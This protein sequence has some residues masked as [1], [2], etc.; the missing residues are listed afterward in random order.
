[1]SFGLVL[2]LVNGFPASAATLGPDKPVRVYTTSCATCHEQGAA[3]APK[4]SDAKQWR[5][6]LSKSSRKQMVQHVIHGFKSM[7]PKGGNTS[8]SDSEVEETVAYMI[9]AATADESLLPSNP[10][11]SRRRSTT[12]ARLAEQKTG[13]VFHVAPS[14]DDIPNDKYGDDVR[15]G[16]KIFTETYKYAR[17]YSGNDLACANCHLD[18]GRRPFSAPLWGAYG[19]Y[20]AYRS[21]DDRNNTIEDRIQQCFRF[22]MNGISPALDAP[23]IRALVSYIHFLSKGIPI[24]V[25]MPGRGY[26]QIAKTGYDPNPTRGAATYKAKCAVC[27]GNSGKGKEKKGGGYQ[28]PPLW[29]MDS[30]NKGA[31]LARN[32]LLAGFIKANMPLGQEWTLTDQEA[33]DL[34]TYI[35]LQLRPWDPRKGVIEGLLD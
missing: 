26:L 23:E 18:A 34:A 8:L 20:P 29:G 14:D 16:K 7:P 4:L 10:Q 28:F 31:G 32:E 13:T 5:E 3:G 27:H 12:A 35:N 33:L 9:A 22:S 24:G 1:M 30:Y 19:M 11:V 17:R 15:L 21:K 2:H 25:E 6:R